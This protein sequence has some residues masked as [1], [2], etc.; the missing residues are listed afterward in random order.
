VR[1]DEDMPGLDSFHPPQPTRGMKVHLIGRGSMVED[2][3]RGYSPHL[4]EEVDRGT[5][6]QVAAWMPQT[7]NDSGSGA[8]YRRAEGLPPPSQ[9]GMGMRKDKVWQFFAGVQCS[10]ANDNVVRAYQD[11]I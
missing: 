7:M 5:C 8:Y 9:Y 10:V 4:H 3:H 1:D 2:G 6:M 11:N